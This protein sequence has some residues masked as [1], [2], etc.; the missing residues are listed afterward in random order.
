M[1][2]EKRSNKKRFKIEIL[3]VLFIIMLKRKEKILR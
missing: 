3:Q 1:T 2:A